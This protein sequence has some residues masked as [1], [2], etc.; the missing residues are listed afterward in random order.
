MADDSS[1]DVTV[2]AVA[3]EQPDDAVAAVV[4]QLLLAVPAGCTWLVPVTDS[5]GGVVD[6]RVGAV[7]GRVVDLYGRGAD[8]VGALLGEL[9][10]GMVGGPLWQLYEEVLDSGSPAELPEFQYEEQAAGVVAESRFAISVHRVLG[11]LLVWWQRIDEARRRLERTEQLGRLGWAEYD[12]MTGRIEWSPGMYELL[13]RD[14][15]LGPMSRVEQAA[16]VLPEDR[17][18]SEAVW[19]SLDSGGPADVTMRLRPG[20]TV[21]YLRVLA[22]AARDARGNPLKVYAV[23]Q[24]VTAREDSR[25]AI[26]R[27]QAQLHTR[28]MTAL[29][30][31]RLARQLQ[32]LIQPVPADP[33]PLAGLEAL[34]GYVPA[35]R[36]T[37]VGGDWYHAE[38]LSDG[39]VVLAVGDVAG[40]GLEA[41]NGMAHLRFA[42]VG[43]LTIGISDP[44]V[45]LGHM[46]QL[47]QR[48]KITATAVVAAYDPTIREF[49]WARAG[50]LPPLLARAGTVTELD[51]PRGLLLGADPQAT[52]PTVAAG[53]LQRDDVVLFYTDGLVER[54][55]EHPELMLAQVRQQLAVVS[56]GAGAGSL[57]RL[58][59]LLGYASPDDDTCTL[60]VRVL[61]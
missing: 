61:A 14:P 34:A 29:A 60:A 54:R 3:R 59:D 57:T 21:K 11:G 30:E 24:D 37:Q 36:A 25:T 56:A 35:E 51:P 4:R 38:I 52:Y 10:P 15:A 41:A 39:T 45:L 48:L 26:E 33:F 46:N 19:Q 43:W 40:H 7:S 17:G 8:R 31:H 58:R 47:C 55:G 6:F 32:H 42:L 13:E 18:L 2:A 1:P 49:R 50:H 20:T 16:V 28:E 23:V 12:L 27:L 9:Y 53:R 44:G 5:D 22:E